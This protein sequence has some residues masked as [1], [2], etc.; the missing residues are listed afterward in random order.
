MHKRHREMAL[1][2]RGPHRAMLVMAQLHGET[3]LRIDEFSDMG[4]AAVE[5]RPRCLRRLS[6]VLAQGL[7]RGDSSQ[8]YL[9]A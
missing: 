4:R 7:E 9:R 6:A 3:G 1:V 5:R 8:E 2:H